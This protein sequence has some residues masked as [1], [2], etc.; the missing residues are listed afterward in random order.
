MKTIYYRTLAGLSHNARAHHAFTPPVC[1]SLSLVDRVRFEVNTCFKGAPWYEID[2]VRV[3]GRTELPPNVFNVTAA[4]T[5]VPAPGFHGDVRLDLL[6]TNCYGALEAD[7]EAEA[8]LIHVLPPERNVTVVAQGEGWTPIA[9]A[10]AQTKGQPTCTP[11]GAM[12]CARAVFMAMD[13]GWVCIHV[14]GGGGGGGGGV[15]QL[16]CFAMSLFYP[17]ALSHLILCDRKVP[18]ESSWRA[19]QSLPLFP[20]SFSRFL[21][22]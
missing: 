19:E 7:V 11:S 6:T 22:P 17:L 21:S 3:R 14:M 1:H 9:V 5:F 18:M 16:H 13:E 4:L 15:L 8:L 2:A 10:P 12:L 20:P